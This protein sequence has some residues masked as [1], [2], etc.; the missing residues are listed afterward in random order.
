MSQKCDES[1]KLC[2][3]DKVVEYLFDDKD[4]TN[5]WRTGVQAWVICF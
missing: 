4:D 1:V 2:N 5:P 3:A